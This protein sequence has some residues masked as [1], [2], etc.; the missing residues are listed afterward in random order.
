[1]SDKELGNDSGAKNKSTS[2]AAKT[3]TKPTVAAAKP[4]KKSRPMLWPWF[5]IV[6]LIAILLLGYYFKVY[7]QRLQGDNQQLA[8]QVQ[9]NQTRIAQLQ[10]EQ[11]QLL[12]QQNQLLVKL[13]QYHASNEQLV[14]NNTIYLLRQA[15]VKLTLEHDVNSA[16][17]LLKMANRRVLNAHNKNFSQLTAAIN[18]DSNYLNAL[19]PIDLG[20]LS[21]TFATLQRQVNQLTILTPSKIIAKNNTQLPAAK[22]WQQ[23]WQQTLASLKGL[24]VVER[25]NQGFT[26]LMR[27]QQ[28]ILFKQYLS[29]ALQQA[30]SGASQGNSVVYQTALQQA[31]D[32]LHRYVLLNNTQ[33]QALQQKLN[34][35]AK[36][37]VGMA[38]Y[39][40]LTS[41][42]VAEKLQQQLVTSGLKSKWEQQL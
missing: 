40:P 30:L 39:Q 41:L 31:E 7:Q 27:Q 1:M 42:A 16:L 9:S 10:T 24:I 28:V 23:R 26:P 11:Q 34:A 12:Q 15:N 19:H 29:G 6:I 2:T 32:A 4:N 38:R 20:K 33:A 21:Q 3:K 17:A 8:L 13:S 18:T 37:K 14:I 5:I 36:I 22:N 25:T 35:L